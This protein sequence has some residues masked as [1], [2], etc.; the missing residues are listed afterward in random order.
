MA[1]LLLVDDDSDQLAMRAMVL[2]RAGYRV[3]VAADAAGARECP[4]V[5]LV[6]MDLVQDAL[7]LIASIGSRVPVIVLTGSTV[8]GLPVVRVLRKPCP[9]RVLLATIAELV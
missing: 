4:D 9:T 5:D 2:E 8:T 6:I 3:I 7:S 1:T